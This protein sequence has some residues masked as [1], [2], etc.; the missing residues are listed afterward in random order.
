[1]LREKLFLHTQFEEGKH[2][3]LSQHCTLHCNPLKV[4]VRLRGLFFVGGR[5]KCICFWFTNDPGAAPRVP[6]TKH[7]TIIGDVMPT[8]HCHSCKTSPEKKLQF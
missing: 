8:T 3:R 2:Q 5:A 1:M 4:P 7:N 6:L